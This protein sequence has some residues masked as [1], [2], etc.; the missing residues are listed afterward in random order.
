MK[1]NNSDIAL[2]LIRVGL[3]AV[4]MA[5]G[6]AKVSDMHNT[7]AFF[8]TM[9]LS[10]FWAYLVAYVEVLGGAAMLIGIATGWAGILL[11]IVMIGSTILVKSS[12]GFL[13]GY[14]FDLMLFLAALSIAFSGPGKYKL[15]R[16]WG[17]KK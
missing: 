3:G 11:A 14:E 5:H 4:F 10:A 9:G 7:V 8:S 12:K 13:G 15:D 16:L 1:S 6:Y 17:K 2:L